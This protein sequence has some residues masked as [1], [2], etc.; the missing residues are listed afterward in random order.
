MVNNY[1]TESFRKSKEKAKPLILEL[2][3]EERYLLRR[4]IQVLLEEEHSIWQTVTW[5]A[6]G[7]LKANNKIRMSK[8]PPAGDFPVWVYQERLRIYDIKEDIMKRSLPVW[9]DFRKVNS[10][11]SSHSEDIIEKALGEAGFILVSRRENTRYFNQRLSPGGK[12]LDYIALKDG[13]FYGIEVKQRIPYPDFQGILNDKKFVADFHG[14]QFLLIS[15]RLGPFSYELFKEKGLYLE[16]GN[17]FWSSENSSFAKKCEDILYY[18]IKCI[19]DPPSYL[20]DGLKEIPKFH[21]KYFYQ[22]GRI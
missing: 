11:M 21:D 18:P 22:I 6:L 1:E 8:Y 13:V 16:F 10:K 2:I 4:S 20:I 7:E 12:N 5:N 17:L 3:K 9:R 14:I 15:R 19:D